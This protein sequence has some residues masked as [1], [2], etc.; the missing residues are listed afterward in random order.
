[1]VLKLKSCLFFLCYLNQICGRLY[2]W[3]NKLL[4]KIF[5]FECNKID[6][7]PDFPQIKFQYVCEKENGC[8]MS[9]GQT[10]RP[11]QNIGLQNMSTIIMNGFTF[12]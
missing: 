4:F 9:D 11:I 1:M 7:A 5:A 10:I 2:I 3:S 8:G 12:G 6:F